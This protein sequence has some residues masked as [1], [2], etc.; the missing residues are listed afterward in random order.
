LS[1]FLGHVQA[2]PTAPAVVDGGRVL[3]YRQLARASAA[4]ATAL[5]DQYTPSGE[6]PPIAAVLLPRGLEAVIAAVSAQLAGFAHLPLEPRDPDD[7]LRRIVQDARPACLITDPAGEKL[8]AGWGLPVLRA[9]GTGTGP[10]A[11]AGTGPGAPAGTGPGAPAESGPGAA[12]DARLPEPGTQEW[13][14][15]IYTSG[16]SGAPRGALVTPEGLGNLVSAHVRH[17]GTGPGD[18]VGWASDMGFDAAMW[19][20]WSTLG[21]GATLYVADDEVRLQPE[22]LIG[23]LTRH[24]ITDLFLVTPLAS[25]LMRDFDPPPSLRSLRTGG[26]RLWR[27]PPRT[28]EWPVYNAYG[29]TEGTVAVTW[30]GKLA[31]AAEPPP[32][33]RPLPGVTI[34]VLDQDGQL[35]PAGE[36]GEVA[37]A[38][39]SLALGYLRDQRRTAERWVPDPAGDGSRMYLTGDIGWLD[40]DGELRLVG[41]NDQQVKVRGMRI[42]LGE[43]TSAALALDGVSAAISVPVTE[44]EDV[45]IGL[46]WKATPAGPGKDALLHHLRQRLP[47]A[48]VPKR[49]RQVDTLPLTGRGKTDHAAAAELLMSAD[50]AAD[51]TAAAD[52]AAAA[53]DAAADYLDPLERTV[54]EIFAEVTEGELPAP[55]ASFF[56]IGGTSLLAVRAISRLRAY[57]P[58]FPL[59]RF[60][61]QP[62]VRE[63]AAALLSYGAEPSPVNT[64]GVPCKPAPLSR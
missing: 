26:D 50:A 54:A 42:E 39:R 28:P 22:S 21:A 14:A 10:D 19:D 8:A 48:A 64:G 31:P 55:R 7:R 35:V 41:R 45:A 52:G 24:A 44:G 27:V 30:T 62:T 3:S 36:R 51:D 61:R 40:S 49:L 4:L 17:F 60:Y 6:T 58:G 5:R 32:V 34:S 15:V 63:V 43:I 37:V 2:Q 13:A 47:A 12:S 20:V 46:L 38:G 25:A 56:E 9:A 18:R 16:T 59:V 29:P 53:D 1:R 23:W 57:A 33:G 11:P